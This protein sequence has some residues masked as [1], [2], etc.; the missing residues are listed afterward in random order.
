MSEQA[1]TVTDTEIFI[2][3]QYFYRNDNTCAHKDLLADIFSNRYT[4]QQMRLRANDGDNLIAIGL[5]TL[6]F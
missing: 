3:A 4:G 6:I 1:I 2:R 5:L